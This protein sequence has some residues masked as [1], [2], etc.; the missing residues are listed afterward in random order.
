MKNRTI[1]GSIGTEIRRRILDGRYP[2][3][4]QLRQDGLAAEFGASR[5]PVREALFQLEAEGLVRILPHRG[6][7]VAPLSPADAAEALELYQA[8]GNVV[9]AERV[10]ASRAAGRTASTP[11]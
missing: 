8:K 3:G 9:A 1:A 4:S 7:M 5:I 11:G 2:A 10:R 6:A